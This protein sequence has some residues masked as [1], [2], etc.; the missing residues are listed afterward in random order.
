MADPGESSFSTPIGSGS[1][2]TVGSE[3]LQVEN[4]TL[5]EFDDHD[6]EGDDFAQR[7][8]TIDRPLS[9]VFACRN[10]VR[11]PQGLFP[12]PPPRM[13]LRFP[14]A[15]FIGSVAGERP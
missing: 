15:V 11:N 7:N 9:G 8:P 1:V 5:A 6:C 14:G 12:Q 3:P 13:T 4:T 10:V 2:F